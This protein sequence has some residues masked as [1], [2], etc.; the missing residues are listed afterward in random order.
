MW[1]GLLL[2]NLRP[3]SDHSSLVEGGRERGMGLAVPKEDNVMTPP[4][5]L[6]LRRTLSVSLSISIVMD[7]IPKLL[8]NPYAMY[9]FEALF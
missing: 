8:P 3:L 9:F 7:Y 5:R 1:Q 4:L 2:R 6:D